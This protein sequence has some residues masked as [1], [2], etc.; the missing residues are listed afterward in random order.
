MRHPVAR[1]LVFAVLLSISRN[2]LA[3]GSLWITYQ[4]AGEKAF[5]ENKLEEAERLVRAAMK[6]AAVYGANDPQRRQATSYGLLAWLLQER[7]RDDDAKPLAEWA[8]KVNQI[9]ERPAGMAT[10][11]NW[12]TLGS[13]HRHK[14]EFPEAEKAFRN[15]LAIY[16]ARAKLEPGNLNIGLENIALALEDQQK[17]TEAEAIRKRILDSIEAQ[18]GKGTLETAEGGSPVSPIPRS[19]RRRW[20][21]PRP[22]S[23]VPW[24]F[25]KSRPDATAPRPWQA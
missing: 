9:Y 7:G 23:N 19:I 17:Y 25:A 6:E 5:R 12:N 22:S 14:R 20:T 16:E 21:P 24:Q 11:L 2:A 15:S 8:L 13:I 3:Q 1:L 10:A 18:K 4:T